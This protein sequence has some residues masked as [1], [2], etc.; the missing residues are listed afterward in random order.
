[1]GA[2]M[3]VFG[4]LG[5]PEEI[6]N[7]VAFLVGDQGKWVTGHNVQA[8]GGWFDP[9]DAAHRRNVA[10]VGPSEQRQSRS[11]YAST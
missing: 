2:R 4:R 8:C 3:S 6:A 7:V 10:G 1:M 5:Q 9:C 11:T